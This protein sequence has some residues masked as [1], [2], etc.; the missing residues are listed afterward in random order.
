[1]TY[2]DTAVP[3]RLPRGRHGLPREMVVASQRERIV[4][5][6]SD[7][8]AANGYT[9]TSIAQILKQAGVSRETFYEQF[10]SKEDCF[11]QTFNEAVAD[12]SQRVWEATD[13]GSDVDPLLRF[14]RLMKTYLEGLAATPARTKTLLVEVFAAGHKFIAMRS[15]RQAKFVD[16][17]VN[18]LEANTEEQRFACK[19]L[20]AGISAQVTGFAAADDFEGL[21]GMEGPLVA[22]VRRS[23][24]L[25]GD[26][27]ARYAAKSA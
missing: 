4:R 15:A 7:V 20:V 23:G 6:L 18:I 2:D 9:A 16:I 17:L 10:R 11:E 25:Y 26:A 22:M 5:A 14:E 24:N 27:P 19:L 3:E 1:M 12:L 13:P 21:R 8:M